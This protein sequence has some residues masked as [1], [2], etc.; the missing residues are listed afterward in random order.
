M[1]KFINILINVIVT[2]DVLRR[3]KLPFL[4]RQHKLYLIFFAFQILEKWAYLRLS[5]NVKK[6]KVFQLQEALPLPF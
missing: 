5:V 6:S 2:C 3:I 4:R 1:D